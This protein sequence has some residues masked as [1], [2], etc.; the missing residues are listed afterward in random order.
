MAC[1]PIIAIA[2]VVELP[3]SPKD[4]YGSFGPLATPRANAFATPG[5][6]LGDCDQRTHAFGEASRGV[7]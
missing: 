3:R 5:V 6:P 4:P 2:T 7:A 1:A